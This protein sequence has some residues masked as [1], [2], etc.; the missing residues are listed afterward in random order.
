MSTSNEQLENWFNDGIENNQR[1][2]LIICDTYEWSDYPV[3]FS[4][5]QKD[6]CLK[7]ISQAQAGDNM[8]RLMECYD[9]D[10]SKSKQLGGGT[11]SLALNYPK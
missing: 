4:A 5:D 7:R 3:Y 2:M 1:W 11:L 6:E 10:I 8:Q 9:F